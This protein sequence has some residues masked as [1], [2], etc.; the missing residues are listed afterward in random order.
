MSHFDFDI[1]AFSNYLCPIRIHR[2][3][4]LFNCKLQEFK[5]SPKWTISA[6]LINFC[7][8]K[9]KTLLASLATLNKIF[10]VIFKLSD[11]SKELIKKSINISFW[12]YHGN[13]INGIN[14]VIFCSSQKVRDRVPYCVPYSI[15]FIVYRLYQ[16]RKAARRR[17]EE[18]DGTPAQA[19]LVSQAT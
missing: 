10:S 11:I 3:V 18:E 9:M 6:F 7:P 12:K 5:H 8:L 16:S 19:K 17:W 13:F 1:L 2:L 15:K 4:T 14:E